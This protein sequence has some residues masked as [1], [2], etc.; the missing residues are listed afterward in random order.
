MRKRSRLLIVLVMCLVFLSVGVIGASASGGNSTGG[1]Q[2]AA[3]FSAVK[4]HALDLADRL[5]IGDD[6]SQVAPGTLD[7][8]KD[9]LPQA[10]IS[11]DQAIEA[12]KGA[13]SGEAGE[14]DLEHYK[15]RLVFNVDV[16]NKDVKVDAETGSVLSSLSDD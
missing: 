12:A 8:G 11:I 14:I 16:G 9:L 13:Q 15:G 10:K 5:G 3:V 2:S 1:G 7:D 6:E 4:S